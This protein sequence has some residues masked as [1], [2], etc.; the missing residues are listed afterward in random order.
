MKNI[1]LTMGLALLVSMTLS[2]CSKDDDQPTSYPTV[3]EEKGVWS[4]ESDTKSYI[5]D[6]IFTTHKTLG[7]YAFVTLT[8]PAREEKDQLIYEGKY[9]YD[10]S[11]GTFILTLEQ[12][13]GTPTSVTMKYTSMAGSAS[14]LTIKEEEYKLTKV[15]FPSSIIGKWESNGNILQFLGELTEGRQLIKANID[16][17]ELYGTYSYDKKTGKGTAYLRERIFP[18]EV[19]S[20]NPTNI[21][22]TDAYG[23]KPEIV[24]LTR[25][26]T[27]K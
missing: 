19:K 16:E 12:S 13:T 4:A 18:Y 7:N 14:T 8:N 17:E 22:I 10:Q 23:D 26:F 2:S 21:Y 3:G 20:S 9:S 15:D 11:T 5:C 27:V 6:V 24:T 1:L 25:L